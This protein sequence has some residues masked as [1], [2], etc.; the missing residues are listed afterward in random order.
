MFSSGVSK[1]KSIYLYHVT[2]SP[3]FN[4]AIGKKKIKKKKKKIFYPRK[5]FSN[6]G[7]INSEENEMFA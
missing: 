7:S 3:Y 5:E 1:H 2:A 6:Q 4:K